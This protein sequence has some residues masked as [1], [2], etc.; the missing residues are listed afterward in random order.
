MSRFIRVFAPL[1][2]LVL[3]ADGCSGGGSDPAGSGAPSVAPVTVTSDVR[4]A[5]A[6]PGLAEW[7]QPLMDLYAPSGAQGLPLVVFLPPH[8]MTKDDSAAYAQLATAVA[9]QGVVVAVANWSQLDDPPEAFTD[10]AALA[11]ISGLGQSLAGCA[12]SYAA[13]HAEE[14]GADPSRLVLAG[15]LFGANAASLVALGTPDPF[16]DCAATTGWTAAGLV[17]INDDWL[18]LY[19]V[20]DQV[21][22]A[23]VEAQSPWALLSDAPKIPVALVVTEAGVT[24]SQRC[25]DRDSEWMVARDPQ[26]AM[27]GRLDDVG[28]YGDGCVDLGDEAEAMAGEMTAQGFTAEVVRLANPDGAT[29]SDA[30]AHFAELGPADLAALVDTVMGLAD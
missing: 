7:S 6:A 30:G 18:G 26:G 29:E 9:E 8:G 25:G 11:E 20:L 14:Y 19:P 16:P 22:A 4:F 27:R 2:A 15:E 3:L 28:A 23:A 10:P 17:G 12:V 21:A 1:T 13:E 5:S 24:A